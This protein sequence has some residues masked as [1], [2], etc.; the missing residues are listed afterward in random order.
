MIDV[1][2]IVRSC[3]MIVC[4]RTFFLYHFNDNTT[5][6]TEYLN[7]NLHGSIFDSVIKKEIC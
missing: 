4:G 5:L 1:F 6:I 3:T 7:I 2:C